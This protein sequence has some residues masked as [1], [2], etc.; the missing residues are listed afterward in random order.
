MTSHTRR[1]FLLGLVMALFAGA[2]AGIVATVILNTSLDNYAASLF[3]GRQPGG[4]V[5]PR[6]VTTSDDNAR[7]AVKAVAASSLVVITKSSLDTHIPASLI[8][9]NAALGYGVVVS[10]DGWVL[11]RH[12]VI[13]DQKAALPAVDLWIAG[14]RYTP[15]QIIN[16]T[17]TD[18]VLLKVEATNLT[19][20][21]FAT[22]SDMTAGNNV[23]G[24]LNADALAAIPVTDVRRL[25]G[26]VVKAEAFASDWQL[27]TQ[28]VVS[29]PLFDSHG[30]LIALTNA[31]T[32]LPMDNVASFVKNVIRSGQPNHA[33]FGVYVLDLESAL[34]LDTSFRQKQTHGALIIAPSSAVSA[35]AKS[36][37]AALVGLV[38]GDVITQIDGSQVD[39][40]HTL[41]ELL[42]LY[43]PGETITLTYVHSGEVKT[44]TLTLV[45]ASNLLY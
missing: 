20:V 40:A 5:T 30:S 39:H 2:S 23:W 16:D 38:A 11:L 33:G 44:T 13:A 1:L 7:A 18:A 45:D 22:S 8:G 35:V 25:A 3:S 36:S 10:T 9:E 37:P 21:A 17:L 27:A 15:K 43:S 42:Q 28:S 19:P 24:A 41:A 14:V 6:V 29:S 34:N 12:V 26:L 4:P 32:A 31:A